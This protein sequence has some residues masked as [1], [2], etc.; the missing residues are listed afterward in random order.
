M[1]TQQDLSNP[2][3]T[4]IWIRI[5]YNVATERTWRKCS[6]SPAFQQKWASAGEHYECSYRKSQKGSDFLRN[7]GFNNRMIIQKRSEFFH[8]FQT[9]RS[10]LPGALTSHVSL[11]CFFLSSSYKFVQI[12][13]ETDTSSIRQ[14][15]KENN[16]RLYS[17]RIVPTCLQQKYHKTEIWMIHFEEILSKM[18]ILWNFELTWGGSIIWTVK[19]RFQVQRKY[20][21]CLLACNMACSIRAKWSGLVYMERTRQSLPHKAW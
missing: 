13:K 16:S 3:E 14:N 8:F 15:E 18:E 9:K 17:L 1:K 19:Y 21:A 20:K 10:L 11:V 2:I 7:K 12:Q 4:N 5:R 6:N